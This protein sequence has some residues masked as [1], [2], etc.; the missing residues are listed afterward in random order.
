M[1]ELRKGKSQH[2]LVLANGG[3]LTYQYVV[4]LSSQ[5]GNSPYPPK[6][7]LPD[8]LADEPI[9]DV[10]EQASGEAIIE[11]RISFLSKRPA[12]TFQTYTVEFN[13]D[14]TPLRGHVI[15]RLKS[16]G[17]RFLENHGDSSALYQLSSRSKE[18]IGR[19]GWVAAGGKRKN[20]FTFDRSEKL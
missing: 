13:R 15:G 20:L 9:H 8:R 3:L 1:R 4:C 19:S 17:H 7:S 18:Q 10:D 12:L 2:G 11:V 16:N 14:G 5:P 6:T